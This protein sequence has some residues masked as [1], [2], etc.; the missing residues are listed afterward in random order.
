M[1]ALPQ[2]RSMFTTRELAD[3]GLNRHAIH[4]HVRRG[5]LHHVTRGLYTT[6]RPY[7]TLLL[8]ALQHQRPDIIFTGMTA[9]QLRRKM[10]ISTPVMVLV[11]RN[12]AFKSS[13]LVTVIRADHRP[14]DL[15][16]D[17][18]VALPLRAACDTPEKHSQYTVALIEHRYRGRDGLRE[19]EKDL[20][21]WKKIPQLLRDR[22]D[23][24]S[25]GADSETERQFF[26]A[27]RKR[28][29]AFEQNKL[30]GHF[31]R[32]G[33]YEPGRVMVEINGHQFHNHVNVVIKDYWKANDAIARGY[34]HLTFS[35]A[36][37]DLHLSRAVDFT[38]EV[39]EGGAPV[40]PR[41]EEW[42]SAWTQP[43]AL[44]NR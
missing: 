3:A 41:M 11:P 1:T 14:F 36:C 28:G 22:I 25:I 34:R 9:V 18:R 37:I 42:H 35:D 26:R 2:G 40:V 12:R 6:R 5:T 16:D 39:I 15:V 10:R 7:G 27:L 31:F 21:F 13:P 24:A 20:A 33:V 8:R 17:L 43:H 29:Y 32:D 30:I 23:R 44:G 38:V 19:L 4:A